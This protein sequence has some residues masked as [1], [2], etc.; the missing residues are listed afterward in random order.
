MV[1]AAKNT[2]ASMDMMTI[3]KLRANST[4]AHNHFEGIACMCTKRGLLE[5][6][7][8]AFQPKSYILRKTDDINIFAES[9]MADAEEGIWILK[10]SEFSNRGNGIKIAGSKEQSVSY[11]RL[12]PGSWVV[13][14]YIINPLLLEGRKFD[15]RSYGLI[16]S[17]DGVSFKSY[18][19]P[20]VYVRTAS[21]TFSLSNID[22]RFAHLNNDAVQK[23]G[24]NYGK[25]ENCNK[26]S[27]QALE[28]KLGGAIMSTTVTG[29]IKRITTEVFRA[30]APRLNPRCITGCF[31]IVGF[32]FMIDAKANVWLIEANTNPCH[33][34]VNAMLSQIIP[35]MLNGALKL[36][37]DQ[38][39]GGLAP[40]A[41]LKGQEL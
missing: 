8:G 35:D 10:P 27:L 1:V 36:T 9:F 15:I 29:D 5:S 28:K 20:T 3:R 33:E 37:V 34:L 41:D 17:V 26:L 25:N 23:H 21:E 22:N 30:C 18:F 16:C 40:P 14:K 38:W 31:E 6:L 39:L 13:Q 32:D 2:E 12:N 19:Y 11:L 7:S 4:K 24:K